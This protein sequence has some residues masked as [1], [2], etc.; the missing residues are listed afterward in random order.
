M[1]TILQESRNS[2]MATPYHMGGI[3]QTVVALLAI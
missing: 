3:A 2:S 1:Q